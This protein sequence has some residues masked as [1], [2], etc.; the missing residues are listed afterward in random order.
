MS[1]FLST[2]KLAI[3]GAVVFVV[4]LGY[5]FFFR[6]SEQGALQY[7]TAKAE[8]GSL[9]VAITGSGNL[10][11][12]Q[13]ATVDPTITGTVAGLAVNVGDAV[14]KGQRLFT[15]INEDL[16]ASTLQAQSS[17][18]NAEISLSQARANLVAAKE[19]GSDTE[20]DRAI[21]RDKISV[22][23]KN[24]TVAKLEYANALSDSAKR[25]VV[26][27]LDGTVNEINVKNGD[28][29]GRL[30]KSSSSQAPIIIGDLKT[31]KAQ[32][33]VNEVDIA[34]VSLGQKVTMTYSAIDG[35]VASGKVEKIDALGLVTQGVVNYDVTIGLETI[36]SRLRPGMSVS[37]KIITDVKQDVITVPN[38]ALKTQGN[39]TYVEV[40]N[41]T[42]KQPERRTIEIGAANTM[43]TEIVSGVGVGEAVVTQT[44]DPN[45]KA[46]TTS[47]NGF[48]FPGLGGGR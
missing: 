16:T 24:L 37:A 30:A 12:D 1:S 47:S 38:S 26:S 25:Q 15:I 23:E 13:L 35:L 9:T 14:K 46:T 7:M 2:H 39:K 20:R 48:R 33:Q 32:V 11:V 29:L 28:D 19:G 5:F 42:T 45:A 8:R 17:F 44:I 22:A 27:P 43:D 3:G 18:Q 10:V 4:I 6:G 34:N 36:D 41:P 40:L 21:L 31:L